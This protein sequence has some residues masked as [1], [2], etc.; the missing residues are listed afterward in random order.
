MRRILPAFVMA[1]LIHAALLMA[2]AKWLIHHAPLAPRTQVITMRL[3]DRVPYCPPT[4][5][6]LPIPPPP[7]PPEP[8]KPAVNPKPVVKKSKTFKKKPPV[9]KV[10]VPSPSKPT[11]MLADHEP[12]PEPA[13]PLPETVSQPATSSPAEPAKASPSATSRDSD[14]PPSE[15]TEAMA[16]VVMAKPRYSVNPPPVYPS[17]AR[18]RGYHGTVILEVFV[19][20]NGR[21]G[22]LR[23]F[24]SST[25]KLLDRAAMK[26]V[27]R[28][29]FEPGRH[30]DRTVAMWVRV[31]VE[32]RL[33]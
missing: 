7:I 10:P 12:D 6:T 23:I 4:I 15:P 22:D 24:Q 33:Q 29:Q 14:K 32:F 2:D 30:G 26:A 18:R 8:R 1:S 13:V 31:P 16:T 25:H 21:V 9:K 11:P 17:I 20:E 27:K 3:V 5:N 19:K 28:W